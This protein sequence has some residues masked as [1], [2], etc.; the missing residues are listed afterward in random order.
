MRRALLV[1]IGLLYLVSVPWYRDGGSLPG[2]LL[3]L[4]DWVAVAIGCYAAAAVLN[5]VAW[6]LWSFPAATFIFLRQKRYF[7]PL[8]DS[9]VCLK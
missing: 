5:A 6:L 1:L 2:M 8:V 9:D 3:G 7:L 4:P